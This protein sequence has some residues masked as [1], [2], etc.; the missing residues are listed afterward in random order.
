MDS[1]YVLEAQG[2]RSATR[3]NPMSTGQP[4]FDHNS[5]HKPWRKQKAQTARPSTAGLSMDR[6]VSR[7]VKAR[8]SHVSALRR[9]AH[10]HAHASSQDC[11][12]AAA[13]QSFV[14]FAGFVM[15]AQSTQRK[16][17]KPL[18]TVMNVTACTKRDGVA[19][20]SPDNTILLRTAPAEVDQSEQTCH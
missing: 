16:N 11:F 5:L 12:G 19:S 1:E 13:S 14:L 15:P 9:H 8:M 18:P 17:L 10:A 4:C 6:R 20:T 3:R 2:T 7:A